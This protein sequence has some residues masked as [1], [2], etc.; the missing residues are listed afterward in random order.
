[1]IEYTISEIWFDKKED[2]HQ[3]D[4]QLACDHRWGADYAGEIYGN[5]SK[6][7]F[8][9]RCGALKRYFVNEEQ[10]RIYTRNR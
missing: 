4:E 2:T 8:C 6:F 10:R 7:M 5:T 1:M 9:Q 3:F